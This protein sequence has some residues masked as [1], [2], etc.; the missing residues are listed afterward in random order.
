VTCTAGLTEMRP[1]CGSASHFKCY[2]KSYRSARRRI[3]E[4]SYC[5]QGFHTGLKSKV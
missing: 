1:R 5:L 4:H 3:K 2:S